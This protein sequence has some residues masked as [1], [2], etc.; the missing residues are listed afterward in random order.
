MG[1]KYRVEYTQQFEKDFNKLDK[2]IQRR[3]LK[4]VLKL[5]DNPERLR[6]L[7]YDLKGSHRMRIGVY[8]LV[9]TVKEDVVYLQYIEHRKKAY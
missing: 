8:R 1:K 9:F 2:Q 6:A 7:R 4:E 5:E 3:V